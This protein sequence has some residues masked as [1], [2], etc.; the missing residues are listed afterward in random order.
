MMEETNKIVIYKVERPELQLKVIWKIHYKCDVVG[1]ATAR[2]DK[3]IYKPTKT[4]L[5]VFS[6]D[7]LVDVIPLSLKTIEDISDSYYA[8][9]RLTSSLKLALSN[10]NGH[11]G[12]YARKYAVQI[13]QELEE[14]KKA[15]NYEVKLG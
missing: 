7:E 3:P 5:K 8:I 11:Q 12:I 1:M 6:Q 15:G 2:L 9:S 13:L 4:L 10:Y 14:K